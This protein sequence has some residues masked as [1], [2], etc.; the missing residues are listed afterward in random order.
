MANIKDKI[1]KLLA[2]ATSSNENEARDALLKARELMAKNKLS[3][4]DFETKEIKMTYLRCDAAKWTT[5]S[6]DIWMTGLC[7]LI[8]DNY[9]CAASWGTPKGSRTHVLYINGLE[10]DAEL[11]KTVVEYAVGFVRGA[12]KVLQRRNRNGDARAIA[13]SYAEGFILGLEMAFEEQKEDHPEWGLV[14]VKP[15]EVQEYE[16]KLGT[17]SVR[18]KQASFDPLAYLR[19]QND[20]MKF[21]AQRVLEG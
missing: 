8:C 12:I 17:R 4:A 3:D 11:C 5:D 6:G 18:T 20:G 7:K 16:E 14:V 13:K 21:N 15:K 10:D 9:L 2:L 1:K 19:G